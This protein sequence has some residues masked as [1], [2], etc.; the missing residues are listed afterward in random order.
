MN[1]SRTDTV[2]ITGAS[3]GIGYELARLFAADGWN[4]A[5][6][7]RTKS[8]L[9][10]VR[11]E[12][13]NSYR[14]DVTILPYDLSDPAAPALIYQELQR[15]HIVVD[16]LVNNAG[17]GDHAPFA[18]CGMEKQIEMVQVNVVALIHLTRL[19]LPDMLKAGKGKIMNVASTAAFLPGPFMSIYYATKA[20]VLSFSEALSSEARD[21]GITV[22][23]FCPGP[24][25]T[26]FNLRAG[27][28]NSLL[29]KSGILRSMTA[30]KAA[31]IGYR[32]LMKGKPLAIS[33]LMNR[34][35]VQ[36]LRFAPRFL[37][38]SVML[39]I[40]KNR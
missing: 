2:L 25:S 5:L 17:F 6:N 29:Q 1:S 35:I 21:R 9:E 20:F 32:A 18:D 4:L 8:R 39:R 22:T 34:C 23:A 36:A 26:N 16:A 31:Q 15:L 12:L 19:I 28:D 13:T 33:G 38:R 27:V 7:A 40:M 3:S 10:E 11:R 14:A 30:A 37:V 24:T